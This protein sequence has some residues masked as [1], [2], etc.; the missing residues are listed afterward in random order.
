MVIDSR[1]GQMQ[2]ILFRVVLEHGRLLIVTQNYLQ[3]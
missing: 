1:G 3:I 2:H